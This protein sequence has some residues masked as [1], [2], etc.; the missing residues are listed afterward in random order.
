MNAREIAR[1]ARSAEHDLAA[2][3]SIIDMQRDAVTRMTAHYGPMTGGRSCADDQIG[4]AAARIVE[5][6]ACMA[7]RERRRTAEIACLIDA[8]ALLPT[9]ESEIAAGYYI[10]CKSLHAIAHDIGYS[11]GYV[12]RIKT[13]ADKRLESMEMVM[14]EWYPIRG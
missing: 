13:F 3:K 9:V 11:D 7:D 8:L 4:A 12:R 6:E 5:V 14:P 2:L 1:N 10:H